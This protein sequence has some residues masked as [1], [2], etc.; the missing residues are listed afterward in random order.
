MT[1]FQMTV[2]WHRIGIVS[3]KESKHEQYLKCKS[4]HRR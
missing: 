2:Y 1:D 3:C 4:I